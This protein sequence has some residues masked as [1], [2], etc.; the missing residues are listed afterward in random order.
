[1]KWLALVFHL[2]VGDACAVESVVFE[3]PADAG[4]VERLLA[5]ASAAL[6]KSAGIRGSFIQRKYLAEAP[7]PL[8]SSGTYLFAPELGVLWKTELPYAEES[9]HTPT[10]D[11]VSRIFLSLVSLDMAA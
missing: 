2:Y 9:L 1:M 10:G 3:H 7:T 11:Q 8:T 6:E 4:V 5:P